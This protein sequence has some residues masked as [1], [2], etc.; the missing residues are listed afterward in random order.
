MI[1]P[2]PSKAWYICA[3]S[4]SPAF[5]EA[6]LALVAWQQ[7]LEGISQKVREPTMGQIRFQWWAEALDSL[8][9]KEVLASHPLLTHIEQLLADSRLQ[10]EWLQSIWQ[11]SCDNFS[12]GADEK[13]ALKKSLEALSIKNKREQK[14]VFITQQWLQ[15]NPSPSHFGGLALKLLFYPFFKSR[16]L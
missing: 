16:G 12:Q 13:T 4:F 2:P 10:I 5:R 7:E 1:F 11:E 9:R 8:E 15:K 14:K 6:A 3:Q